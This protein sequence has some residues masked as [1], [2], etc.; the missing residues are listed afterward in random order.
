M[1]K[2]EFLTRKQI[3]RDRELGRIR[4]K[5][6][7]KK[8]KKGKIEYVIRWIK[9]NP[10][11]RDKEKDK[12]KGKRRRDRMNNNPKLKRVELKKRRMYYNNNKD[13]MN[14]IYNKYAQSPKGRLTR[15]KNARKRRARLNNIIE[16][17]TEAE[18][19]EKVKSTK[20]ICP[21]C[22]ELIGEDNLTQD[23]IYS[24]HQANKDYQETGIKRVYTI[25]DVQPLCISCN[26]RRSN[27][28]A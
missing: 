23:H 16:A 5:R 24:V 4:A 9:Q 14:G 18:W 11:Y 20:G 3:E 10:D 26:V 15:K 8:N 6:W 21:D 12:K 19:A 28:I 1:P 7:Y 27:A 13:K 25:D 22:D 17:F 2:K